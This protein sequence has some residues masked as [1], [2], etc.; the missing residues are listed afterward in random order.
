M[1]T[2][3]GLVPQVEVRA[4][5]SVSLCLGVCVPVYVFDSPCGIVWLWVANLGGFSTHAIFYLSACPVGLQE[6]KIKDDLSEWHLVRKCP[7]R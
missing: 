6:I 4:N 2:K 3:H 7:V 1:Y 5:A